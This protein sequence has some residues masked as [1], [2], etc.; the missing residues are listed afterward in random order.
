[1]VQG[2]R[3]WDMQE[4]LNQ[5]ISS[6]LQLPWEL[7]TLVIIFVRCFI[8]FILYNVYREKIINSK[9]KILIS[10]L[11]MKLIRWSLMHRILIIKSFSELVK[12]KVGKVLKSFG[13]NQSINIW[14]VN[15][16]NTDLFWLSLL[17]IHLKIVSKWRK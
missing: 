14:D 4:T 11:E 8:L 10:I 1:M 3:K 15:H 5:V 17:W 2:T 16:Q 13:I 6:H 12:L 9:S 7:I